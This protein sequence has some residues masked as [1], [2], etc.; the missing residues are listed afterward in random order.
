M[1]LFVS[2]GIDTASAGMPTP[3][4]LM[5]DLRR[6]TYLYQRKSIPYFLAL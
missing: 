6:S 5:P 2:V 1:A 3:L 4:S